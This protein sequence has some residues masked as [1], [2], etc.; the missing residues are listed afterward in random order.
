MKFFYKR[1]L[2]II[3]MVLGVTFITFMLMQLAPGDPVDAFADPTISV[4]DIDQI[5]QNLG[6]DQPLIIQYG[7]WLLNVAQGNLGYSYKTGKPVLTAI[8]ERLPATLILSVSAIT[9]ILLIAVPLGLYSGYRYQTLSDTIITILSFIGMAMPTFWVGLMMILAF[10]IQ[11]GWFPTSGF[12]DPGLDQAPLWQQSLNVIWHMT[13]PLLATIVGDL[14][15]LIRYNRFE[16]IG[17]L[18]QDYILAAR[19]RGVSEKCILFKHAFKNAALPLVTILGLSL[20]GLISG[21]F[22]I[23]Y[24]FSWPGMG[25]LGIEAVFSRDYPV[26][27]GMVMISSTLILLG[28]L[29]ADISYGLVD[30]KIKVGG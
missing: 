14:A 21:S 1:L 16:V 24:I 8:M 10:S 7:K 15:G 25:Q 29:L 12:L 30:P 22:I 11:L 2:T 6:L 28:N 19:A 18:K 26:L 17:V 27:M 4:H 3:P 23:E 5:R 13:L 9:L 20:P